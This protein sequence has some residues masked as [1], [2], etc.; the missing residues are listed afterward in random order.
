MASLRDIEQMELAQI[1]PI[2][3]AIEEI[4]N[5]RLGET[6]H[7]SWQRRNAKQAETEFMAVS[8]MGFLGFFIIC[9]AAFDSDKNNI[10]FAALII[11]L[12][13]GFLLATTGARPQYEP[14]T[15]LDK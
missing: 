8:I 12:L 7:Q 15:K 11:A 5:A 14:D 13:A 2:F 9:L 1:E 4:R 3:K 10:I 6:P